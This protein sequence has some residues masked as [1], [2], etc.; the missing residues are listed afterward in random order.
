MPTV[1]F[2][3]GVLPAVVEISVTDVP[4]I[5]WEWLEEGLTL[6]FVVHVA[7]SKVEVECTMD[8]YKDDYMMEIH[9]RAFDLARACVNVAAFS[10]GYGVT[11]HFDQFVG[12]TG[13]VHALIFT[14]PHV[15]GECTAFKMNPDT[16]DEK[17]EL[18]L[19]L[20][21]VMTEPPLFMAL[22]DLIQAASTPHATPT[23]CGRVLDGL[24]KLVA[25]DLEPKK[26]WPKFQT[27]IQADEKYL[28][29]ISEHSKNPRHGE[30]TRIDGRTTI[31]IAKRTWVI[32]NR[33]LEFRKRGNQPLPLAEFP[34]LRG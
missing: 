24:R 1:Y 29:F 10:T 30:H 34:L 11:V 3:G 4:Q 14:C 25:P 31:E 7:K 12:P 18:E 2:R 13:V 27:T 8:R 5:K 15:V 9:R 26:A 22:N 20:T 17:R 33:F 16:L 28:A 23:N 32:M 6:E 21:L 19:I